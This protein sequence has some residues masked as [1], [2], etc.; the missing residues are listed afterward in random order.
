MS[1]GAC[2]QSH[3]QSVLD[4][5]APEMPQPP[6]NEAGLPASQPMVILKDLDL[7]V[8][9]RAWWLV[10]IFHCDAAAGRPGER[11]H[12]SCLGRSCITPGCALNHKN[13]RTTSSWKVEYPWLT[14]DGDM[15]KGMS[16]V[17]C[18][19]AGKSDGQFTDEGGCVVFMKKNCA[20]HHMIRQLNWGHLQKPQTSKLPNLTT[21]ARALFRS[22]AAERRQG[23]PGR[24]AEGT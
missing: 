1:H 3:S 4:R 7:G 2:S 16:C 24:I 12:L 21:C 22:F 5:V 13:A 19:A 17:E 20:Q 18:K 8:K 14:W 11:A 15:N 9:E 10:A 23:G 6:E